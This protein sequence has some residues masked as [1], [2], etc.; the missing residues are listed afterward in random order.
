MTVPVKGL[1]MNMRKRRAGR[2]A[3]ETD[4]KAQNNPN[5]QTHTRTYTYTSKPTLDNRIHAIPYHNNIIA[6]AF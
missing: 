4:Q 6:S 1:T 5:T 2:K 3:D